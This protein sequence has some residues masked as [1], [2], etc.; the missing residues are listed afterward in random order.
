[1]TEIKCS[2]CNNEPHFMPQIFSED[3]L[4][5]RI[6]PNIT[7]HI[8]QLAWSCKVCGIKTFPTSEELDKMRERDMELA[9]KRNKILREKG[10][11]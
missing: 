8:C 2:Y 10:L 7:L 1:M 5:V 3:S 9:A 11:L 4:K 6:P